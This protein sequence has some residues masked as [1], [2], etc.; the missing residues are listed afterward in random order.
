LSHLWRHKRINSGRWE[1]SMV[2]TLSRIAPLDQP[3]DRMV[4]RPS[5]W[6]N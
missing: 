4:S 3:N 5:I 6:R 2:W 1:L